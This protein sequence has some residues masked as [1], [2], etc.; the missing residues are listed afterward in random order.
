MVKRMQKPAQEK[1]VAV[2]RFLGALF[3]VCYVRE[4]KGK[5]HLLPVALLKH[6]MRNYKI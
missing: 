4:M 2:M 1:D 3:S 5:P 6:P